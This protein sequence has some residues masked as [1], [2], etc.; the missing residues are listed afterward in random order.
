MPDPNLTIATQKSRLAAFARHHGRD[1]LAF[2]LAKGELDATM[3]M[4]VVLEVAEAA[5]DEFLLV[6]R[7]LLAAEVGP[8]VS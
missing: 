3:R 1:S 6:A 7:Q 4:A 2:R 5:P 8:D